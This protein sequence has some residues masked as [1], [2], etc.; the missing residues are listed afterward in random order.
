MYIKLTKKWR[1]VNRQQTK[2]QIF[3]H[4]ELFKQDIRCLML[5]GYSQR[6]IQTLTLPALNNRK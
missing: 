5:N 3:I 6:I 2:Y 4:K 1:T